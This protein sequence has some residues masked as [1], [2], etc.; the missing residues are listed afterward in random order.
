[1]KKILLVLLILVVAALP[2]AFAACS[3]TTQSSRLSTG[4]V[5]TKDGYELFSYRVFKGEQE[6]GTMTMCFRPLA[7]AEVSLPDPTKEGDRIFKGVTGTRLDLSLVVPEKGD[8]VTSSVIYE[9][10]FTPIYS[11]KKTIIDGV[12][13]EMQV[14]YEEKTV[15]TKLYQDGKEI[16]SAEF[17]NSGYYDNEMLYALVRASVINDSSYSFTYKCPNALTS[18]L[19]GMAITRSEAAEVSVPFLNATEKIPCYRFSIS[20]EN[21]YAKSYSMTVAQS[22]QKVDGI[23]VNKVITGIVEGEYKYNLDKVE[24]K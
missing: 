2:M 11:Y 22:K 23:G 10:D 15:N 17:K 6:I 24:I 8:S 21:P 4:Y 19:D 9:G 7:E 13:K 16:D 12:T 18:S 5:C 3:R 14:V 1:M 20:T